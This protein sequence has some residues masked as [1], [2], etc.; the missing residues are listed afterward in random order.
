MYSTKQNSN[1]YYF[2]E[3]GTHVYEKTYSRL[4][5]LRESTREVFTTPVYYYYEPHHYA[6]PSVI[7]LPQK[8]HLLG[9]RCITEV[10]YYSSSKDTDFIGGLLCPVLYTYSDGWF[11]KASLQE[12]IDIMSNSNLKET[13]TYGWFRNH[14]M[15]RAY[16]HSNPKIGMLRR[17]YENGLDVDNSLPFRHQGRWMGA[18]SR[19]KEVYDWDYNEHANSSGW[20]NKKNRHQWEHNK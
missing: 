17:Y 15:H 6:N 13:T 1:L 9:Y 3:S 5:R 14:A 10:H 4:K 12:I 19:Y 8:L 7:G 16:N 2:D 20:K 18:S 11:Y